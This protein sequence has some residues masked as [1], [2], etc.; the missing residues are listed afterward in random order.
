L[1]TEVANNI[2]NASE[3]LKGT[4]AETYLVQ[5]RK[6]PKNLIDRFQ[7]CK[8]FFTSSL[9]EMQNKLECLSLASFLAR[10]NICRKSQ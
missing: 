10:R 2:W 4:L 9:T 7:C 5:H 1:S 3:D 8:T 6:I